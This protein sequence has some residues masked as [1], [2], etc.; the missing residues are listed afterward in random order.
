VRE[1]DGLALSSRNAYLSSN[2]RRAATV[3][4]RSLDGARREIAAGGRDV[5]QLL[6]SMRRLIQAEPDVSLDYAEIVDADSLEPV[7]ALRKA[8]YVLLAAR[9]GSTRLIDN[10]LIEPA[11][12]SLIVTI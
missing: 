7:M 11:G 10:G 3:L 4:Y 6:A 9:V 2:D 12:D 8:C 1:P 5:V